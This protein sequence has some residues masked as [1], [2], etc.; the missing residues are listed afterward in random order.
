M[1]VVNKIP[2]ECGRVYIEETGRSMLERIKEHDQDTRSART[3]SSAVSEHSNSTRHYPLRDE[4]KFIDRDPYW[5]TRRVKEAIH[6]LLHSDNI[7]RDSGIEISEA[8]MPT[9]KQYNP[10]SV[11]MRTTEGTISSLDDKDRNPPINNSPSEDWNATIIAN[12]SATYADTQPDDT[13]ALWR[14]A[15]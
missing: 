2:C 15:V 11:P 14:P 6:I 7:N 8:R 1:R 4:V 12:Y 5:Y 13:I 10:H 9:I 3:Q